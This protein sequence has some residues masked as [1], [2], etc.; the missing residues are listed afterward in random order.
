MHMSKFIF[1]GKTRSF[2]KNASV[3]MFLKSVLAVYVNFWS[4]C[5]IYQS[6]KGFSQMT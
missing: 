5:V 6:K 3:L 2:T 1:K 4:I